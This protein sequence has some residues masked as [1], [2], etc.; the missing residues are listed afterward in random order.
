MKTR[1][2]RVV[3]SW[4][5][6]AAI[7]SPAWAD[8]A[9]P[10]PGPRPIPRPIPPQPEPDP[11]LEKT[12]PLVIRVDETARQARLQ[13]PAKFLDQGALV[14]PK[15]SSLNRYTIMAGLAMSL[16][17][18]S[19]FFIRRGGREAKAAAIVVAAGITLGVASMVWANASPPPFTRPEPIG[20]PEK[21]PPAISV[22]MKQDVV[23]EV[24]SKGDTIVLITTGT[25]AKKRPI[26]AETRPVAPTVPDPVVPK[27][28]PKGAPNPKGPGALPK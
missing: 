1:L 4:V 19:L 2:S 12:V 9:P 22:L 15:F 17:V 13:I 16:A 3:L 14:V 10:F 5:A 20:K 28:A 21:L 18:G 26:P 11:P 6:L 24:V 25:E 23:V 27:P 7:S 8:I